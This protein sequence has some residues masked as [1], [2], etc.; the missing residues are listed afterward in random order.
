VSAFASPLFGAWLDRR[1]VR[2]ALT[3]SALFLGLGLVALSLV[4]A[5]W[6]VI[7]IY[8]VFMSIPLMAFS[9]L[10]APILL[11][12]WF[13]RQRGRALGIALTGY[14]L[15]GILFPPLL[16]KLVALYDWR[17]TL[18]ISGAAVLLCMVP[19]V[20]YLVIDRP[21]DRNTGPDG[22]SAQAVAETLQAASHGAKTDMLRNL[23]FWLIAFA[24]GLPMSARER[25]RE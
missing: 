14:A 18:Q 6:Q 20:F 11:S 17:Q 21:S 24:I 10:S 22:E 19:A 13:V 7:L 8:T 16:I 12:R 25:G 5:M 3:V 15:G 9:P 23:N 4:S 2:T 1:S